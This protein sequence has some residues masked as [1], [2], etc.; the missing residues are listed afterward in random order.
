MRV[1]TYREALREALI[2]EMKRDE[3]V[4]IL[5]EDVGI[6]GGSYKVTEGLLKIFGE[7]RVRDTPISEAT[8]AGMA[9]GAAL[10]GM[11][12]VAEIM[13]ID[14]ITQAMDQIVNQAA[15]MRYMF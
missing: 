4:F 15:K 7:E 8:I 9:I 2:E 11:R 13:Y 3:R 12:P 5:G 14:F 6:Y 1:I 10:T